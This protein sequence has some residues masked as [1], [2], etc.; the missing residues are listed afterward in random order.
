M[1]SF[2]HLNPPANVTV[3]DLA[4]DTWDLLEQHGRFNKSRILSAAII[5]YDYHV[6][7]WIAHLDEIMGAETYYARHPDY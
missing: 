2:F 5:E 4:G 6:L 3:L 1:S 7:A